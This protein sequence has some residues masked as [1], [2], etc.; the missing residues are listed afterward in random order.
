MDGAGAASA[1]VAAF[2]REP[3][4]VWSAPGRVNLIG[5]HTDY[6]GGLVLPFAVDL[7]TWAAAAA[8]DDD[9][10]RVR[11]REQPGDDRDIDATKLDRDGIDGWPAYVAGVVATLRRRGLPVQ[12]MDIYVAGDV[13]EGA[14][15]S[16]SAAVECAVAGAVGDA[17]GLDLDL[18][19]IAD[20]AHATET[21]VAGV[22]CGTM[23]QQVCVHASAG[24][25]LLLDC[26]TGA[27][28]HVPFD[29]GAA[30]VVTVV[31]DTRTRH[32]LADGAYAERRRWCEAAAT[33]IGVDALSFI[34]RDEL[35]A[36]L[37]TLTDEE[38]RRACRH[39]VTENERVR[40]A[41]QAL[42][43]G[44]WHAL[45]RLLLASHRSLREDFAVSSP[46]LDLAVESLVGTGALGARMT[47][48][49]F[50][51]SVV[52]LMP[53]ARSDAAAT[54]VVDA[55]R[56]AGFATPVTHVVHPSRGANR[57]F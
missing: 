56:H 14:G 6:N 48:A 44:D 26:A 47:G 49:G 37:A 41:V 30:G 5:E 51:G 24:H 27:R 55:F 40:D 4:G 20:V 23:D 2:G 8:R 1:F 43:A 50:G 16:S 36:A 17:S 3:S 28:E 7:R 39:V 33:A 18:E 54:E 53:V 57:H 9:V 25:A 46:E 15:L 38:H 22:P 34:R 45:G 35:R 11:S 12:G 42:R 21:D 19:A 52:A 31:V 10:V 13:P 29:P 32:A